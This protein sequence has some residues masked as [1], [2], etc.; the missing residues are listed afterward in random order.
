MHFDS[1]VDDHL[2][3]RI[4]SGAIAKHQPYGRIRPQ[5]YYRAQCSFRGL[6]S[7]GK[8]DE[9]QQLLKS[10]DIAQDA[11]IKAE[12]DALVVE[13]RAYEE[14]ES[15]AQAEL[16]WQDP[17]RTLDEK[18]LRNA[19][20]ALEES[21]ATEDILKT[22]CHVFGFCSDYIEDAALKLGLAH[23][24]IEF[25]PLGFIVRG[26][27]IV[28]QEAAVKATAKKIN[29]QLDQQRREAQASRQTQAA[30]QREAARARME[31]LVAEAKQNPD[32]DITGK[33]VVEC[34]EL[35]EYSEGPDR[36]AALS[37]EIWRDDFSLENVR[38]EEFSD[39]EREDEEGGYG[40]GHGSGAGHVYQDPPWSR[41]AAQAPPPPPRNDAHI[42]RFHATFDFGPVEGSMRIFPPSSNRRANSPFIV[43][44]DPAFQYVWRGRETGEGVIQLETN[45]YDPGEITFANYG[46]TFEGRFR[47]PYI[48]G[49]VTIKGRKTSHGRGEQRSSKEAWAEL[50]ERAYDEA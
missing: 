20:R 37:M 13:V 10:R 30:A 7:S 3:L 4:K 46:M 34:N 25:N 21:L 38:K 43:K 18:A 45:D 35:A 9:L 5:A 12:L 6:R 36:K 42:P 50:S 11:R 40:Y 24:C 23:E 14:E 26:R 47:C 2:P 17:V 41:P 31:Q 39:D 28:G 33:W 22:G 27:Q 49:L 19:L 8:T 15:K 29:D 44:E 16:W 1:N 32:W 48:S